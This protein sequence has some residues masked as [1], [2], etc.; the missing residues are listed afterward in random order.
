MNQ[1]IKVAVI[2]GTGKAGK[3]VVKQIV[4]RGFIVRAFVRNPQ[5]LQGI[6]LVEIV[7]GDVLDYDSVLN[8]FNGCDA[9]ISTLGQTKGEDP[10]FSSAAKNIVKAMEVFQI[11]R[12]IVLTGL[13]LDTESD[14]K[15]L[16]TKIQSMLMRLL[17][18]KIIL[19]KQGEYKILLE[20]NLD[21]TI[22]RI[23]FLELTDN[24]K[25]IET[26]LEDCK[27]SGIGSSDLAIFIVDQISDKTYFRKAP[28]IWNK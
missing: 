7:P 20:S 9:V 15:G 11:K 3:Y 12:Y 19:D 13:T 6:G 22:V 26:S 4:A 8:L 27:G 18:R 5:K 28:F 24:Q 17:F 14:K 21:W 25:I 16:K 10:V 23:P 1:H 2:G